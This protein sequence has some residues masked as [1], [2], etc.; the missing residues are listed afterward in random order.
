MKNLSL[1]QIFIIIIFHWQYAI[2]QLNKLED[3]ILER[4][5]RKKPREQFVCMYL[6]MK[7][8]LLIFSFTLFWLKFNTF[9][10]NAFV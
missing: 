8:M 3:S 5:A 1:M 10:W 2:S 7:I 6:N 9:S 4:W